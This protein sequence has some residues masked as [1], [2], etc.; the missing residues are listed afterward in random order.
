MLERVLQGLIKFKI[1][2][3]FFSLP[4]ILFV[5]DAPI[6]RIDIVFIIQIIDFNFVPGLAMGPDAPDQICGCPQQLLQVVV[7]QFWD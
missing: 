5:R 1:V 6:V 3:Q 4:A 2:V 7:W